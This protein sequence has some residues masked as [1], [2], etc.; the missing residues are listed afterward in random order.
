MDC[1]KFVKFNNLSMD[2]RCN[3]LIKFIVGRQQRTTETQRAKWI[4][5]FAI[6]RWSYL[7]EWSGTSRYSTTARFVGSNL[8]DS[9]RVL[10]NQEIRELMKQVLIVGR[11]LQDLHLPSA[12]TSYCDA[13]KPFPVCRVYR[14]VF[15]GHG[16][17]CEPWYEDDTASLSPSHYAEHCL[18]YLVLPL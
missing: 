9:K 12:L 3:L 1:R 5:L 2:L 18:R 15:P 13:I 10:I 11:K 8:K 7:K 16:W 4:L 14:H 17:S 6:T